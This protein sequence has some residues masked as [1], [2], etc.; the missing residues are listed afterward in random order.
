[1]QQSFN[2][3]DFELI[4]FIV[5]EK[6]FTEIDIII[7]RVNYKF[8]KLCCTNKNEVENRQ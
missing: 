4:N 1:M 3:Q 7:K 5:A 2:K 8:N 6:G